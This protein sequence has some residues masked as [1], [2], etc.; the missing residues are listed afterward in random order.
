MSSKGTRLAE[1]SNNLF[2]QLNECAGT[3]YS[4]GNWSHE[5]EYRH[6]HKCA[7]IMHLKKL[8]HSKCEYSYIR[9]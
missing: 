7:D 8:M 6:K 1:N 2:Q 3:E 9:A 5:D 4:Q